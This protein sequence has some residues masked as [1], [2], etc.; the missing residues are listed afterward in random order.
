MYTSILYVNEIPIFGAA[1]FL[2]QFFSLFK[3]F[4][5]RFCYSSLKLTITFK[6]SRYGHNF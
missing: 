5:L 1:F 3:L 6:Y 2:Y 4:Y